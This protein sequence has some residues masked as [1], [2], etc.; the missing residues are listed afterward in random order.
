MSA[1]RYYHGGHGESPHVMGVLC[2]RG[3]KH[4]NNQDTGDNRCAIYL[5]SWTESMVSQE[6]AILG[7]MPSPGPQGPYGDSGPVQYGGMSCEGFVGPDGTF[8][9]SYIASRLSGPEPSG[10]GGATG[11]NPFVKNID[12]K[13]T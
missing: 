3:G 7:M 6:N 4:T 2:S 9:V 13:S 8:R 1:T 10:L 5:N 12:P 11:A